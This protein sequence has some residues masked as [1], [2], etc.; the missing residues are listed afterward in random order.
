MFWDDLIVTGSDEESHNSTLRSA[1]RVGSLAKA[2]L[3]ANVSKCKFGVEGMTY[4]GHKI[5]HK[6]VQV[7]DEKTAASHAAREPRNVSELRH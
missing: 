1:D 7:T 4:L 3:R 6:G 2:G 5:C